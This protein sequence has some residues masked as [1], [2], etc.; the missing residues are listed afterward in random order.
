MSLAGP[1]HSSLVWGSDIF[2]CSFCSY[3]PVSIYLLYP[4][5]SHAWIKQ[6]LF[7]INWMKRVSWVLYLFCSNVTSHAEMCYCYTLHS[8]PFPV[9]GSSSLSGSVSSSFRGSVL[10]PY[11]SFINISYLF[12]YFRPWK[13][14]ISG[15]VFLEYNLC[16]L[17]WE[18]FWQRV[19]NT[20]WS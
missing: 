3:S 11:L 5:I 20:D 19:Y 9:T 14:Q 16:F 12:T 4:G 7:C 2:P 10:T 18:P 8:D 6:G 13:Q 15:R 1:A 17:H